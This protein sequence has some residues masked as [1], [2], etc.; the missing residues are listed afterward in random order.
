M[1]AYPPNIAY[2]ELT[3]NDFEALKELGGICL[4]LPYPENY[5]LTIATDTATHYSL[6]AFNQEG[7][8]VGAIGVIRNVK[9]Y[10]TMMY[11]HPD[12]RK[13][14]DEY[15]QIYLH[16]LHTNTPAIRLYEKMGYERVCSIP[17]YYTINGVE[18][19]GYVYCR[20]LAEPSCSDWF[21]G[22]S[23]S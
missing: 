11:I 17:G 10:F 7:K 8:L 23:I 18:E 21:L 16:V 19:T 20:K 2:R 22:C 1:S 5:W 15:K 9:D 4:P 3:V 13:L 12:E 6:G 14:I